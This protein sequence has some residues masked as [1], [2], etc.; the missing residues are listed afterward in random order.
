MTIVIKNRIGELWEFKG[1]TLC[2][3]FGAPS[4]VRGY[5]THRALC[6]D[7]GRIG[8]V[9]EYEGQPLEKTGTLIGVA[10]IGALDP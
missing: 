9:A 1:P 2:L 6:L 4:D 10:G 5:V 3:V 7:T 8:Y